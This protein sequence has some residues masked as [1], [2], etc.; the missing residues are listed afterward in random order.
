MPFQIRALPIRRLLWSVGI[1]AS[2]ATVPCSTPALAAAPSLPADDVAELQKAALAGVSALDAYI[3]NAA[4]GLLTLK[5]S[6]AE[7]NEEKRAL[8]E[9]IRKTQEEMRRIAELAAKIAAI[10]AELAALEQKLDGAT[11]VRA[12][13]VAV[14]QD[15][16]KAQRLLDAMKARQA[17]QALAELT[18]L[19]IRTSAIVSEFGTAT[20]PRLTFTVRGLSHCVATTPLCGR[21]LY[22]LGG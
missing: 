2:L 17:A 15:K 12:T 19:T 21:S 8:E 20:A 11:D 16:A 6:L 3:R 14:S 10:S 5:R 4:P 1:A 22:S 7:L 13:L 9:K 18:S